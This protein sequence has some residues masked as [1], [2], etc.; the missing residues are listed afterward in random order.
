MGCH[1]TGA[2]ASAFP[3]NDS[4]SPGVAF[5]SFKAT[6]NDQIWDIGLNTND[7]ISVLARWRGTNVLGWALMQAR[8]RVR[9]ERLATS[10]SAATATSSRALGKKLAEIQRLKEQ[11]T[12]GKTLVPNQLDKMAREAEL[13]KFQS[14]A[15][16]RQL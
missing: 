13:R 1:S 16:A 14:E 10:A 7:D 12:A 11:Q 8:E 5:R 2:G 6:R 4:I 9:A 3:V 15:K